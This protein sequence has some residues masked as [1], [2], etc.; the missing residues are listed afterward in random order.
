MQ[1][2]R[3]HI[4]EIL[5]EKGHAT[6]DEL[7]VE[8]G[9]RTGDITAVTVRYHLDILRS[10]GLVETANVRRRRS[11]GRPQYVYALTEDAEAYFPKNFQSLADHLLGELKDRLSHTEIRDLMLA[12]A[13]RMA[14]EAG[15][16]PPE[17]DTEARVAHLVNFLNQKGYRATWERAPGANGAYMLHISNCP[18]HQVS[19]KHCELCVMDT[20]LISLLT[21]NSAHASSHIAQG[22]DTCTY[23]THLS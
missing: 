9:D 10:E 16:L 21:E 13:H 15:P 18:Y 1:Q 8:L 11:P 20:E 5:K 17:A 22:A 14:T 6:V 19:S 2:T 4:I 23:E 12:V 3:Q 7:V